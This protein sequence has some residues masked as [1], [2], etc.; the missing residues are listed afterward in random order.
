MS[1]PIG[2]ALPPEAVEWL[3][4]GN[5]VALATVDPDGHPYGGIV[6]SCIA[7]DEK[8]LRFAAFSTGQ[9]LRNV[10]ATGRIFVETLGDD[11]VIGIS[12]AARVV[13]DPMDASAYPPHHY[14]MVEIAVEH[15]K[16]DHPPGVQ[17]HGMSYDYGYSRQPEVRAG[18][19]DELTA[20]LRTF[21]PSDR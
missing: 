6:G 20:E 8:T 17:V 15:V 9:T 13:K 12:G 14:V 16:D 18:R 7:L 4:G 21:V 2:D 5:P 1:K 11:L 10:R 3:V 19:R